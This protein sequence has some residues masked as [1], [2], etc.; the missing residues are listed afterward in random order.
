M[1][2]VLSIMLSGIIL[3]SS[4]CAGINVFAQDSTISA[5]IRVTYDQSEARSMFNMVNS[6]RTGGNAWC[7]NE[8][9][10]KKESYKNLS[11]YTYDYDLEKIAM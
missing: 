2:K 7:W 5:D 6:F 8:N 1:K 3:I 11:R 9:N 10:T 4:L